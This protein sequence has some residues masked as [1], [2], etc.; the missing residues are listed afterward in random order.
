MSQ[1]KMAIVKR[2][3]TS[4]NIS[5][6]GISELHWKENDHF[7]SDDFSMFY[8]GHQELRRNGVAFIAQ[9]NIAHAVESYTTINDRIKAICVRAKPLNITVL[10]IYAPTTDASE[11]D[12]ECFYAKIKEALVQVSRKDIIYAKVGNQ[13]E[14]NITG[15]FGLGERNEVSDWLIQFCNENHLWVSN[16]WFMQPKGHLYTWISPGGQYWI[17]KDYILCK[18]GLKSLIN[19]IKTFPGADF[20]SDHELLVATIKVKFCIVRKVSSLK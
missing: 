8:S 6:L 19:A 11:D 16:T 14:L 15:Q 5:L 4:L 9:K 17:Q 18:H 13:V 20:G 12:I 10:Q 7:K 2:E 3:M 1:G